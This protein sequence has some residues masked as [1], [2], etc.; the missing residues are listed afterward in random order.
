M[1]VVGPIGNTSP[2]EC[3]PVETVTLPELSL[4]SGWAHLTVALLAPT[5]G[6]ADAPDGHT[7]QTGGSMSEMTTTNDCKLALKRTE[8]IKK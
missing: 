2:M 5:D 1:T 8:S 4:A 3:E 7:S 6:V